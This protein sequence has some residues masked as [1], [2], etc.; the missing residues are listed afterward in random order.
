MPIY[1]VHI[2]KTAGTS[3]RELML[4]IYGDEGCVLVYSQEP[5][6]LAKVQVKAGL[7]DVVF[8]HFS[9]GFDCTLGIPGR[10]A[11]L[12]R[13]PIARVM[14]F[15]RHQ[16]RYENAEFHSQVST[17]MSLRELVTS[18]ACHETNN[19][20]V[21]ILAGM[22]YTADMVDDDAMLELALSNLYKQF[23]FVGIVEQLDHD[24]RRLSARFGWPSGLS[25]PILNV[26]PEPLRD[27]DAET[28]AAL[29][30][31]NRLDIALYDHVANNLIA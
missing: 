21:R 12:L 2:P 29:Q 26:D 23:D 1:F 13:D 18:Q 3:L 22:A 15:Y 7:A 28:L 9:V 8:G 5:D 17:G 10:Y 30:R 16:E 24:V 27:V 14:S 11:T 19:H 6:E 31:Y 20:M 25:M 4:S